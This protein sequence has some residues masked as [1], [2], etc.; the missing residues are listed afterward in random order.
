M[1]QS[2]P[3]HPRNPAHESEPKCL[4]NPND[5]RVPCHNRNPFAQSEPEDSRNPFDLSEPTPHTEH[6]NTERARGEQK[7]MIDSAPRAMSE[8]NIQ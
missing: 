3:W 2:E 1:L 7:P 8:P 6:V 5:F 4:R